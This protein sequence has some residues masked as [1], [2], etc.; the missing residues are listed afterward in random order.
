[1]KPVRL[2]KD[3]MKNLLGNRQKCGLFNACSAIQ[4]KLSLNDQIQIEP[5]FKLIKPYQLLL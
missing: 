2:V 1:M 4:E 5:F 3:I